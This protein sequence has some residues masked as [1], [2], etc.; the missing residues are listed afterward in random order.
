MKKILYLIKIIFC[1]V[2]IISC[3]SEDSSESNNLNGSWEIVNLPLNVLGRNVVTCDNALY[4]LSSDN[5]IYKSSDNGI[6]W[7]T[8][9]TNLTN[10]DSFNLFCIDNNIYISAYKEGSSN[11]A[12]ST[13]Y[14]ESTDSGNSW[15]QVWNNLQNEGYCQPQKIYKL[16]SKLFGLT[17]AGQAY[18]YT[19][20]NNGLSWIRLDDS[21]YY[22]FG[23]VKRQFLFDGENYYFISRETVYK[24]TDG[25]NFSEI[26]GSN[27]SNFNSAM[28]AQIV[29]NSKL[30]FS[31]YSSDGISFSI[32]GGNSWE[33]INQGLEK[34]DNYFEVI[35]FLHTNNNKLFA[36]AHG[37]GVFVLNTNS[38]SWTE[39]GNYEDDVY[40]TGTVNNIVTTNDY[41]FA[42]ADGKMYRHGL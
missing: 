3:S 25:L 30:Y 41:I 34:Y 10:F 5:I 23:F 26:G 29:F 17:C 20:S 40:V 1:S 7:A 39:I 2:L 4:C 15:T 36:G 24:S 35:N 11:T 42:F 28:T 22:N 16:G 18:I 33:T 9:S 32:D 13:K 12:S 38:S 21:S 6:T 37:G 14:Y 31:G 8:V 27:F 19:S